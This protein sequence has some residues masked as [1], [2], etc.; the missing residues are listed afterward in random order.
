MEWTDDA[1]LLSVRPHGEG[2]ALLALM[3]R[4]QGRHNG[5]AKGAGARANAGRFQPGNLLKATWRGR[6]SEHL[7]HL[8]C[9]TVGYPAAKLLDDPPRLAALTSALTIVET[10][11][12]EREPHGEI[13]ESLCHLID[14]LTA[15]GEG[16]AADYA[17]WE[18]SL[19]GD[20]G[21]GLDLTRCAVSGAEAGLAFVSPKTGRA[22][23]AAAA[24]PWAGKLIALPAFLTAP[25][26]ATAAPA[27]AEI[28]AALTLTGFFLERYVFAHRPGGMAPPARQRLADRIRRAC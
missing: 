1:V 22:V 17:R 24:E 2:N 11:L 12:P 3:T 28:D 6:L 20:L 21:Y 23:T 7:G 4:A 25:S 19:L 16:W 10:A 15:A 18:L 14:S 26:Q 8:T 9:E 5:L 13:F 27:P